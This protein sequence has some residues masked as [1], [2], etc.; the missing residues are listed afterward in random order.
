[1]QKG[2]SPV[3][4]RVYSVYILASR[5]NGTLYVGMTS[6][7]AYRVYQHKIGFYDGFTKRYGVKKLVYYECHTNVW[8]AIYRERRIK[9]WMRSW[10]IALIEKHNPEWKDL[11]DD[12]GE[13]LPLPIE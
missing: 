11:V 3:G 2:D 10:K 8:E 12:D 7:L 6:V 13:I 9:K 1:M 4:G 5:E